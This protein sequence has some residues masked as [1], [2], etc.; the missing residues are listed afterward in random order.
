MLYQALR[1]QQLPALECEHH[2]E[3]GHGSLLYMFL[4]E[5]FDVVL[6]STMLHLVDQI[7]FVVNS[8]MEARNC[9]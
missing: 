7:S 6:F 9:S 4:D 1:N 8:T 2:H 3:E 5:I